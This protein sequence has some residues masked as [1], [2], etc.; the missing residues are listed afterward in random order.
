MSKPRGFRPCRS[1]PL[2]L[3]V[4][5]PRCQAAGGLTYEE[6]RAADPSILRL[7]SGQRKLRVTQE[8]MSGSS[9]VRRDERPRNPTYKTTKNGQ[10]GASAAHSTGVLSCPSLPRLD[11]GVEQTYYVT[12]TV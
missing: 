8:N 2:A 3:D 12:L 4:D 5:G 9:H 1:S 10:T 11:G 6:L 7:R